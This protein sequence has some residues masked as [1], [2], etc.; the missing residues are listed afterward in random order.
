[1]IDAPKIK[2]MIDHWL[3]TPPNGYFGQSYGADVRNML[4]RELSTD[5]ADNFLAQLRR[6]IPLLNQLNDSQL[7]I[8]TTTVGYDQL[9]VYLRVG[10]IDIELGESTTETLDQDYYNVRAQ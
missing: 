5:N 2:D 7:S 10:G 8:N 3:A 1:M 6:D 4:L 9:Y